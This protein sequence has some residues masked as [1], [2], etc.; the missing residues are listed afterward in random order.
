MSWS[1]AP[2]GASRSSRPSPAGV[3]ARP[4]RRG[5]PRARATSPCHPGRAA[6]R[7]RRQGFALR[8]VP[9]LRGGVAPDRTGLLGESWRAWTALAVGVLAITAHSALSI[10]VSVM[11]KPMLADFA[12]A[13]SDFAFTMTIRMLSMIAVVPFAG[14][15]TD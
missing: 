7:A 4:G 11:M 8:P 14:Q 10:A 1:A 9:G 3:A 5:C 2:G 13:R 12:W 15:L 6:V